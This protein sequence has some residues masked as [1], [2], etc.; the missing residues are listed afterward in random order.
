MGAT[1]DLNAGLSWV[2]SKVDDF[3]AGFIT[4]D[5]DSRTSL[6]GRLGVRASWAGSLAPFID[7]KVL[8]EFKGNDTIGV[9]NGAIV[10]SIDAHGRGTWGRIEAGIAGNGMVSLWGEFG[11]VKGWGAKVGFRF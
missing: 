7:A 11:N 1:I 2:K 4:F 3:T 10:D 9:G 5:N 8:H 6:R